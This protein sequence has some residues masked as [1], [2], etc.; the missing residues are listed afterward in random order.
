[1][2]CSDVDVVFQV[3]FEPDGS[4]PVYRQECCQGNKPCHVAKAILKGF[5]YYIITS[6]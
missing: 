3:P 4:R 1:M 6:F 5:D 2:T